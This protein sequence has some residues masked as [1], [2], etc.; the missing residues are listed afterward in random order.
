MAEPDLFIRVPGWVYAGDMATTHLLTQ[1]SY[2]VGAVYL[3]IEDIQH[4][5]PK[6]LIDTQRLRSVPQQCVQLPLARASIGDAAAG[7]EE[8]VLHG[9]DVLVQELCKMLMSDREGL[10]LILTTDYSFRDDI[11]C[12]YGKGVFC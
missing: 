7:E 5:S 4:I 8:R 1:R 6:A 3:R 11:L 10:K 12:L 9:F 2:R